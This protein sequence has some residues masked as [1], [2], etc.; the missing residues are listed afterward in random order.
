MSGRKGASISELQMQM[1]RELQK[2]GGGRGKSARMVSTAE[3][4]RREQFE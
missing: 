4:S 1:R 3:L 2:M